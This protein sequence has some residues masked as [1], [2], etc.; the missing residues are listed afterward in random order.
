MFKAKLLSADFSYNFV[1]NGDVLYFTVTFQNVGD[2]C[3]NG[4][5]QINAD[6]VYCGRQRREQNQPSNFRF[7]WKPFP[8]MNC[9]EKGGIWTT[10]GAWSV[11]ATW[12]AAFDV[13]L[14]ITDESGET[15]AFIG[16]NGK[17]VFSQSVSEIDI[18]WGWGRMRLLKQREPLHI[19]FN[20][21]EEI[22]ADENAVETIS[23]GDYKLSKCCP[24][25]IGYKKNVFTKAVPTFTERNI[26]TNVTERYSVC[27]NSKLI[28]ATKDEVRYEINAPH[29]SVEFFVKSNGDYAEF[30][31]ENAKQ[32]EGFEFIELLIPVVVESDSKK[33]IT[34]NFFGGGRELKL[35]DALPQSV[36]FIYDTCNA[37][38]AGDDKTMFCLNA[39]DP[40]HTLIQSVVK[41]NGK[42][43]VA[44]GVRLYA[45]FP[46]N[47][48]D[49][50][51]I[52]IET[53]AIELHA[54]KGGDWQTA[55]KILQKLIPEKPKALYKETLVTKIDADQSAQVNPDNPITFNRIHDL[56]ECREYLIKLAK[57]TDNLKHIVYIVGWQTGGQDFQYPNPHKL[58]FNPKLGTRELFLEYSKELGEKHNII[59]SFHDN[60]DDAYLSDEQPFPMDLMAKNERLEPWKGWLWAGGMSHIVSPTRYVESDHIDERIASIIE[61]YDIRESYHIDVLTSENRRYDFAQENPTSARK[62]MFAKMQMVKKFNDAGLDITSETLHSRFLDVTGFSQNMRNLQNGELFSGDRFVPLSTLAMHGAMP[63]NIGVE[64][65]DSVLR[66][67][68]VGGTVSGYTVDDSLDLLLTK[69]YLYFM[70]MSNLTYKKV[71]NIDYDGHTAFVKYEGKNH[72]KLNFDTKEYEIVSDGKKIAWDNTTFVENSGKYYYYTEKDQTAKLSV[73]KSYG[74]VNVY[75]LSVKGR[76]K[77]ATFD[78]AKEKVVIEAKAKTPYAIV[79][80]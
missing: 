47:I 67:M 21:A 29:S 22:A 37:L 2:E 74:K 17:S 60:F 50:K 55:G 33:A 45:N 20:E 9:W 66:A 34:T 19:V 53:Q 68:L 46:A 41:H 32:E 44:L 30:G 25:F 79:K 65:I 11:P 72:I 63:Y 38:T 73:P 78:C 35:E 8:N 80:A 3:F 54:V 7:S 36:E 51:S 24:R 75:A 23:F 6:V 56:A 76:K 69:T 12:G 14:S 52:P 62:N 31:L 5:A 71:E 1:E 61:Q 42:K 64:D 28:S 10:T 26:K 15:V 58:P 27:G 59:L 40:D 43:S 77:V 70:P 4:E 16:K 39:L 57:L 48:E 13:K 18:G 49:A